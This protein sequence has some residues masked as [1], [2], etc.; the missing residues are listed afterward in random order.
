M[1]QQ[2]SMRQSILDLADKLMN[3]SASGSLLSGFAFNVEEDFDFL[4]DYAQFE[5]RKSTMYKLNG[6]KK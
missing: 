1:L 2:D 6:R 3:K 5:E 4:D